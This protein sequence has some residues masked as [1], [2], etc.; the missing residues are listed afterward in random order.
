MDDDQL[1]KF[2]EDHGGKV[3]GRWGRKKLEAEALAHQQ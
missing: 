2:I 3:D 1:K